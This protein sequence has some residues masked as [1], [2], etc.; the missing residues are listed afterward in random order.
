MNMMNL[1]KQIGFAM[2]DALVGFTVLALGMTAIATFNGALVSDGS[3]SK[4]RAQAIALAQEKMETLRTNLTQATYNALASGNEACSDSP[5]PFSCGNASFARSWVIVDHPSLGANTKLINVSV[6][7]TEAK[8]GSQSVMLTSMVSWDNPLMQTLSSDQDDF[9]GEGHIPIPTGGGELTWDDK[10]PDGDLGSL[11]EDNVE[12]GMTVY[13]YSDGVAVFEDGSLAWLSVSPGVL[14]LT[15]DVHLSTVSGEEP[16]QFEVEDLK[17]DISTTENEQLLYAIAADAG[18]CSE[19]Y[20]DNGT[21]EDDS[22]DYMSFVCYVGRYWYGRIGIMAMEDDGRMVHVFEYGSGSKDRLCPLTYRYGTICEIT[23]QYTESGTTYCTG[24]SSNPDFTAGGSVLLAGTLDNQDF[25]VKD[26]GASCDSGASVSGNIALSGTG[27]VSITANGVVASASG[28]SYGCTVTQVTDTTGIYVCEMPIGWGSGGETITFSAS[29]CSSISPTQYSFSTGL[30]AAATGYDVAVSGCTVNSVNVIGELS[31]IDTA[32]DDQ[33]TLVGVVG[34]FDVSYDC[35]PSTWEE[36]LIYLCEDIPVGF[37]GDVVVS[38]DNCEADSAT[39]EIASDYTD[40]YL[41][42]EALELDSCGT[43]AYTINGS[44]YKGTDNWEV[45]SGSN[46][47][48]VTAYVSYDD[49]SGTVLCDSQ[50]PG[51]KNTSAMTYSCEVTG[52]PNSTVTLSVEAYADAF[53]EDVKTF[54]GSG[55]V[56]LG[57]ETT[58]VGPSFTKQ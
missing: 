52:Y 46:K 28:A 56:T 42:G 34:G 33:I 31:G 15:G 39:I 25:I 2:T 8:D 18:I 22:D 57:D 7:W 5:S 6:S 3:L 1:K 43:V 50:T 41:R 36:S 45:G 14:K 23:G 17:D 47:T 30:T 54:S 53:P 27:A 10:P 11:I 19:K 21:T 29:N 24:Y 26:D 35:A 32:F 40:E 13:E 16:N 58:I 51:N 9:D 20:E 37:V 44:L 55:A 4:N 48:L 12:Y 49:G 38:A